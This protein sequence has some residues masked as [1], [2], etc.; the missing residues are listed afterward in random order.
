MT[1]AMR[2]V[3]ELVALAVVPLAALV[4]GLATF[5]DQDRLA[6]DFHEEVYPQAEAIVRRKRIRIRIP[7]RRSPTPRT[8]SGRSRPCFPQSR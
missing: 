7:L 8:R 2:R 6:L 3:L 1:A 4:I 5:A